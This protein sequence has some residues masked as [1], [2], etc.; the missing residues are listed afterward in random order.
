MTPNEREL[1]QQ[2]FGGQEQSIT[3]MGAVKEAFLTIAPG[4]K[5]M[6]PEGMEQ[7]KH[8]GNLGRSELANA[9]FGNGAFVLYSHEPKND[10]GKEA[11]TPEQ[12]QD[13]PSMQQDAP[14]Q[15][16]ERG[17]RSM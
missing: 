10:H 5:D 12:A 17:S 16:M 11:A 1:S 4:L 9:L 13:A 6:I 2:L 15:S 3:A 8:M 7:L 14:S